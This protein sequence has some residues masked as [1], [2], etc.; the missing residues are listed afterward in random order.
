[1][2]EGGCGGSCI[3]GALHGTQ[4]SCLQACPTAPG[5][6][7]QVP[8]THSH[9]GAEQLSRHRHQAVVHRD[10]ASLP[11]RRTHHEAKRQLQ[12]AHGLHKA[13][14]GCREVCELFEAPGRA[15]ASGGLPM[16]SPAACWPAPPPP[17]HYPAHRL[18]HYVLALQAARRL[19]HWHQHPPLR[20]LRKQRLGQ[21]AGAHTPCGC[22]LWEMKGEG[23][24]DL[25]WSAA[26]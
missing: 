2:R 11:R 3:V 9:A 23:W 26:R 22:G 21:H 25:R 14:A 20:Q 24:R 17:T 5:K 19:A 6:C 4:R 13:R 8:A 18:V 7:A 1:M 16:H 15:A 10:A 12:Q